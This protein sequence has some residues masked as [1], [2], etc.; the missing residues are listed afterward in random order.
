[1][2]YSSGMVSRSISLRS[3]ILGLIRGLLLATFLGS[4]V[5]SI[6]FMLL[7]SP[8][9]FYIANHFLNAAI[10]R[11]F[12]TVL[13]ELIILTVFAGMGAALLY[14]FVGRR[15]QRLILFDFTAVVVG[16]LGP[17]LLFPYRYCFDLTGY[18]S[19]IVH[20]FLGLLFCVLVVDFVRGPW[21]LFYRNID[22]TKNVNYSRS[23]LAWSLS[24]FFLVIFIQPIKNYTD[25]YYQ[26]SKVVPATPVP[27][28]NWQLVST[29]QTQK[30]LQKMQGDGALIVAQI[31]RQNGYKAPV[32][33][34]DN[35]VALGNYIN[36]LQKQG[37]LTSGVPWRVLHSLDQ[38]ITAIPKLESYYHFFQKP[39]KHFLLHH[40]HFL[41]AYQRLQLLHQG[42]YFT[43][44]LPT[45]QELQFTAH[46]LRPQNRDDI[47]RFLGSSALIGYY[48][49]Y[50]KLDE[51]YRHCVDQLGQRAYC[52]TLRPHRGAITTG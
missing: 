29:S 7:V 31:Y 5:V 45:L 34:W 13:T 19:P 48:K 39:T 25:L 14:F 20:I 42:R 11:S 15:D 43:V 27:V 33:V 9:H 16:L 32:V 28:M 23:L 24:T 41:K 18:R 49:H 51:V 30:D 1:M 36:T 38:R 46:W 40:S 8:P 4:L 47:S 26:H 17:F 22:L 3:I 2:N 10:N 35:L 37:L 44:Q 52:A 6:P 12:N 50:Q 21:V